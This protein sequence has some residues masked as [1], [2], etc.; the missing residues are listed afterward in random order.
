MSLTVTIGGVTRGIQ[1]GTLRI[2]K[3]VNS[4][5]TLGVDVVSLTASWRPTVGQ[6]I[7]VTNGSTV[8]FGGYISTLTE[9]GVGEQPITP[10]RTSI[11]AEDYND[12]AS[13]RLV[14]ASR[15]SETL[16]VR[17]QW[18]VD[19]YLDDY[20]VSL[21]AG[22]ATGPTLD[23]QDFG[24]QTVAEI[25]NGMAALA[26]DWVVWI[27]STKKLKLYDPSGVSAPFNIAVGDGHVDGDIVVEP[28]VSKAANYV[29][30]KAGENA[31]VEKT[32]TFTGNGS[33]TAFTLTYPFVSGRGYVTNAGVYETLGTDATWSYSASTNQITRTSA[34]ASPNAI[35]IVYDAQF[36]VF[37]SADGGAAAADRRDLMLPRPDVYD[38]TVAQAIADAELS[39]LNAT[40][41]TI[42]YRT[43]TAGLQPG[44]TQTIVNSYRN[45]NAAHV[46]TEVEVVDLN[47]M[48][49]AWDVTAISAG[50]LLTW[51]AS[52]A[53]VAPSTGQGGVGLA[54]V[55]QST[56]TAG[57]VD[58]LRLVGQSSYTPSAAD[59]TALIPSTMGAPIHS[60]YRLKPTANRTIHGI[61][62]NDV[63]NGAEASGQVIV[64]R[65]DSAYQITWSPTVVTNARKIKTPDGNDLVIGPEGTT[66]FVYDIEDT[67]WKIVAHSGEPT[68]TWTPAVTFGGGSTGLTYTS[69][70]GSYTRKGNTVTCQFEIQMSAKGSS[71]GAALIGG[72]PFTSASNSAAAIGYFSGLG[73]IELR[74]Y[75]ATSTTSV[76]LTKAGS[77][78]L[79][80]AD[81]TAASFIVGTV[82]YFV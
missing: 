51:R 22:Q 32:D 15:S 53:T 5:P 35:V 81:F 55:T 37:A 29:I 48:A 64:C 7:I 11:T 20:G 38:M 61:Y 74:G 68:G 71:T 60:Y 21:D 12:L 17:A 63:T 28:S 67:C 82:T 19:T 36:P 75:A 50:P 23:A 10:I 31:V 72:L 65:N 2:A 47:G 40:S 66:V 57:D 76:A 46:L 34:P 25:L 44:Q 58:L 8:E 73:S 49:L 42:K 43:R 13:R 3:P 26:G 24:Y 27:D 45:I 59:T 78:A 56:G 62:V 70:T 18:L 6:E 80:D 77:T 14:V 1:A 9:R 52:D 16:K 54:V 69:R 33:T 4:R 39:R 30:V 79:T 41:Q